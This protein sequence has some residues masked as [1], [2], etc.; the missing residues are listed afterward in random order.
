[1][2]NFMATLGEVAVAIYAGRHPQRLPGRSA[3][4]RRR[5]I[6]N[7]RDVAARIAAPDLL[8]T[9][10]VPDSPEVEK[11]ALKAGDLV[12]TSR[13]ALRVAVAGAEHAGAIPGVNL[14]VLR[15]PD[16]LE[17]TLL[18]AFMS[19]SRIETILFREFAGSVTPGFS[20]EAVRR[21]RIQLPDA[22]GQERLSELVGSTQEYEQAVLQ[23][24]HIRRTVA[25]EL[26]FQSFGALP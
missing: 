12:L 8:E 6:V 18:A 9:A 24:V 16:G 20:V 21:L 13:G 14:I 11:L 5:P 7:Q 19:D 3:P 22:A 2:P 10:D 15:P 1:M 23:A 25:Q 17:P 26:V 4:L